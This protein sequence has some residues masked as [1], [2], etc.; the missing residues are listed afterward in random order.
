M[1]NG[2]CL[3]VLVLVLRMTGDD[4]VRFPLLGS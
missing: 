4:A 2:D 1:Q 3:T